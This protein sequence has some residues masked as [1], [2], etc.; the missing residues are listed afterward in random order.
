MLISVSVSLLFGHDSVEY[1]NLQ[2]DYALAI[3]EGTKP[4]SN[5]PLE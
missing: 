4:Q 5:E 2:R 1:D 3:L